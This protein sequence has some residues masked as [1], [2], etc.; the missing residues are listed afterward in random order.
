MRLSQLV[1]QSTLYTIG[2]LAQ[3]AVGLIMVPFYTHFLQPADYGLLEMMELL[4][5]VFAIS[6]GLQVVGDA[7]V[8][9]VHDYEGLDDRRAAVS[10]GLVTA[11]GLGV[12]IAVVGWTLAVPISNLTFQT[13]AYATLVRAFFAA[14]LASSLVEIALVHERM[15]GRAG[16][17]VGYSL[18]Q[19]ALTLGLNVWF[20]AY[21][22]QGVWGFVL[23]KL[24]VQ[25]VGG[26]Y[27]ALRTLRQT[28]L[29]FRPRVLR[30][31]ISFGAPLIAS[32]AGFFIVHFADRFFIVR[33]PGGLGE[34]GVYSLAYKFAFLVTYLV[35]EPFGR[36]WNVSLYGDAGRP[37]WRRR[38]SRIL[39]Y[40]VF[41]LFFVAVG[42]AL[43]VDEA[44]VV[45][46]D[47]AFHGAAGLVPLL[48]LAYVLREFGDFFRTLLYINKRSRLVGLV[49]LFCAALNL[50]LNAWWISRW[51][52]MGAVMATLATF[53]V[54]ALL[55][56]RAADREHRLPYPLMSFLGV[57]AFALMC[58]SLGQLTEHLP[59]ALQWIVDAGLFGAFAGG[60]WLAGYFPRDDRDAAWD[61]LRGYLRR[62]ADHG[63]P[64]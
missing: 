53:G 3:R 25:G 18:I 31:M 29:A 30:E 11:A 12:V 41:F 49:A 37:G 52:A 20:I 4:L 24:I 8:R 23:S 19:L 45:L 33:S 28:G 40:L 59:L 14:Q 5:A 36:V 13:D 51:G 47:S 46:A 54:Y 15:C 16:F 26:A 21:R 62:G 39:R 32:A 22:D 50:G 43:F 17:F 42:I 9:I 1:K 44:L 61:A 38:F 34:A 56:W 60:L 27:L 63:R 64:A 58:C 57:F 6:F 7:M 10:T 55:C 2:N 48:V 35:G